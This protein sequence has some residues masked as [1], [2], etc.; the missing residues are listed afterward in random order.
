M[1]TYALFDE[2]VGNFII[3]SS[4]DD[5]L[6]TQQL[7]NFVHDCQLNY[8]LFFEQRLNH[9]VHIY[10]AASE[11]EYKKMNPPY[12]PE[13]SSGIAFTRQRIII[14]KPGLYY[15]PKRYRETIFHEIAHLYIA[16]IIEDGSLPLWINEGIAMY[17]SGKNISWQESITIG[18]ALMS[19]KLFE[20]GAIDSVIFFN[21][22]QADLAYLESFLAVQF[23]ITRH[24][25]KSIPTIIR[26]FSTEIEL[27]HQANGQCKNS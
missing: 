4:D 3:H 5:S 24:G 16:E 21:S 6:I 25:E 18:N 7:A 19:E 22:A 27:Q 26:Y 20:L 13:W 17:L 23:L 8:D 2:R 9:S 11:E 10:L 14:L 1:S 12:L 15:E